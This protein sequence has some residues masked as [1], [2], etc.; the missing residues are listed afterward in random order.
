VAENYVDAN[1]LTRLRARAWPRGTVIFPKVGAAL[2]TEKRR[3]LGCPAAFDNNVMGLIPRQQV[4]PEFLLLSMETVTLGDYAQQGAVPSV[5]QTLVA[6]IPVALPPLPVQR[7]IVDLMA[8]LDN[9]LA[10]LRAERDA[11]QD[12]LQSTAEALVEGHP[13]LPVRELAHPERGLVGGPFGSS[14]I[15]KDYTP[16]GVPVIR[17]TNMP[18]ASMYVGGEFAFV[19]EEKAQSLSGNQALPGDVVFTQRGT[20]GQV[21]LVPDS[22]ERAVISQSQMRLRVDPEIA[23]SSYVFFAFARPSV[24]RTIQSSNIATANPHI[25]LGILASMEVPVPS[26]ERQREVVDVLGNILVHRDRLELEA[27]QLAF[28]RA[29]LLSGLL[30]DSISVAPAYDAL[31]A[32]AA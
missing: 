8:H 4:L 20:L 28:T 19:S 12:V 25:N 31:L 3:I 2:L 29:T 14:L 9:H 27:Q 1:A 6:A 16:T 22:I 11:V 32:K 21:G 7:R 10:N 13:R 18:R 26:I 15:S 30:Q 24:V 5:N 23:L 17:G